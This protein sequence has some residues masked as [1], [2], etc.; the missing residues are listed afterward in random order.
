MSTDSA[1]LS[2]ISHKAKKAENDLKKY[3]RDL[4]ER[5]KELNCLYSISRLISDSDLS[6]DDIMTQAIQFLADAFQYPDHI[7]GRITLSGKKICH[8]RVSNN[9]TAPVSGDSF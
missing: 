6:M 2:P 5:N 8:P 4:T 3:A 7:C 9:G 1:S